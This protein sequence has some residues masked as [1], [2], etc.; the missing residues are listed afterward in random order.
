[1]DTV[2]PGS[3]ENIMPFFFYSLELDPEFTFGDLC[4]LL[5]CDDAELLSAIIGEQV[6]PILDEAR[7]GPVAQR[8]DPVHFLRVHNQH[9]DGYLL[10]QL[11]AWGTWHEQYDTPE[12]AAGVREGWVSVSLTPV[13]KLLDV[14]LR[15]D[16]E[17]AFRNQSNEIAYRTEIDITLIDFLKAIFDDLTFY[18]A[19]EAR[20]ATRH[21]I[22]RRLDEIERGEAKLIPWEELRRSIRERS[23]HDE[24]AP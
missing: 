11:D 1:V 21:E 3:I 12:A 20:D 7:R 16:P 18:G 10:R 5:D 8:E 19:P 14:P 4:R 9:H 15:Y 6:T 13:N 22:Q 2:W 23:G 24:E 17:L